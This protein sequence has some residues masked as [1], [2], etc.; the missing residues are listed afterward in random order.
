[1][2][3]R[4]YFSYPQALG[5]QFWF[6]WLVSKRDKVSSINRVF[7]LKMRHIK[8]ICMFIVRYLSLLVMDIWPFSF[9]LNFCLTGW[10]P[11]P[12]TER[13]P[14]INKKVYFWWSI[15]HWETRIGHFGAR[16]DENIKLSNFLMKWGCWG[17]WGYWGC[18]DHWGC[19]GSWYQG[20]H[21]LCKVQAGFDFL[22]PKRLLRSLRPV[23]LSC[24]LRSL[25]P[26]RFSE[27][28]WPL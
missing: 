10:P 6:K 19:W 14:K 18:W 23:I 26:L 15:P 3:C 22:R 16:V 17:L 9:K 8:G 11:Q 27:P 25:R 20:N 21:S 12:P 13:V 2:H 4:F 28:L 7:K 1:M 24:L 5:T